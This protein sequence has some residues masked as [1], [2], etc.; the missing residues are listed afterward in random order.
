MQMLV[1][2]GEL[3]EVR[4]CL[5]DSVF[6]MKSDARLSATSEEEASE[7]GGLRVEM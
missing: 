5:M 3:G 6:F 7:I 2:L 1:D 4:R